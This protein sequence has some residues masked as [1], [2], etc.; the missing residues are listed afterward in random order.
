MAQDFGQQASGRVDR[1]EQMFEERV[2]RALE[3]L[4]MPT[5]AQLQALQ[6]RVTA[7]ERSTPPAAKAPK[8][9]A[10]AAFAGRTRA[11]AKTRSR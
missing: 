2:A 3:R 7:L 8:S 9:V 1:L 5:M 11:S 6:E 10:S 4:G